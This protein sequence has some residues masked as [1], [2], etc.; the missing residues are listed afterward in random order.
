MAF[1]FFGTLLDPDVLGFVLDRPLR[2]DEL[3]AASLAGYARVCS[4]D[5]TY[6][7]LIEQTDASV[8]GAIM[9]AP[10]PRDELRIQ[11]FESEEYDPAWRRVSL[12]N[13]TYVDARVFM[14]L[15]SMSPGS[16]PWDLHGWAARHK[17]V[18]LQ[19]C[20]YWMV[21]APS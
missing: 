15:A 2:A 3:T 13:G 1:F 21:D 7:V 8:E 16:E 20:V 5:K 6:P 11:H 18:F 12:T 9:L 14:A 10:S 17:A 19:R 4:A